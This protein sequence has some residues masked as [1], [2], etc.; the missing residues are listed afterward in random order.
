MLYL[1]CLAPLFPYNWW[2]RWERYAV[3]HGIHFVIAGIIGHFVN[4]TER[5]VTQATTFHF[6]GGGYC[7]FR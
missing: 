6:L 4:A 5:Y 2:W 3:L 1:E 7:V